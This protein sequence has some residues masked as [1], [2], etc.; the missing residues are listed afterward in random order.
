MGWV[1]D[2]KV[3][4]HLVLRPVRGHDH[5]SRLE[6]FYAGQAED[7]DRFRRRLLQGRQE[8]WSRLEVPE[9]GVWVDLGGGT[10]SNLELL[11][12]RLAR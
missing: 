11:G 4:Y 5:A 9:G 7:Y 1:S 10:G 12:E 6:S 8:L 2:L 3:L